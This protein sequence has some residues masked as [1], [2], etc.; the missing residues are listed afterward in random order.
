MTLDEFRQ[1]TA[2]AHPPAPLSNALLA[3]WHAAKGDWEAAHQLAQDMDDPTAAWIHAYLHRQEGDL[4]NAA[5]WY[6]R[7]RKPE[8]HASLEAE[9]EQI[10]AVVLEASGGN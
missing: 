7:A 9:W 5:Y 2:A 1:T 8:S 10:A 6:R 4:G 3:L